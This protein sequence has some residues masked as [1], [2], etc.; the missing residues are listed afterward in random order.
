MG[1]VF[2]VLLGKENAGQVVSVLGAT[3]G[4]KEVF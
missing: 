4:A 2:W 1:M 3:A